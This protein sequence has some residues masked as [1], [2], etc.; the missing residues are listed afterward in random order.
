MRNYMNKKF[1]ILLIFSLLAILLLGSSCS[2]KKKMTK[3][4]LR[5]FTASRLIKEVEKNEFD[6]DKFQAKINVRIETSEKSFTVKGQLRMQKDSIIWTSVSLPLGVEMV[7]VKIT[8]DSVFFLNRTDKTYLSENIEDFN[9]ISPI[10][11][12]IKFLQSVLVGN[13]INL[14]SGD[15]YKVK[16]DDGQYN[17]SFASELKKV[18]IDPNLFKITKYYIKDYSESKHKI[19]IQY[20]DFVEVNGKFV[21]TDISLYIH[22]DDFLKVH[23]DY[24]NIVAGEN[25][26]FNFSIP[27][28]YE[29]IF[30]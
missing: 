30:K 16:I 5:D 7:R 8:H 14:R 11:S 20:S 26:D 3:S 18:W 9:D 1:N 19:E 17:L 24:S 10:I 15:H 27:R 23:I 6:F 13:D 29:R 4:S 2:S 22:G 28:K 21:P 25:I 12:S